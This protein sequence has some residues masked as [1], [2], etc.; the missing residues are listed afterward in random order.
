[1]AGR[2]VQ[3][4]DPEYAENTISKVYANVNIEMGPDWYDCEKWIMPTTTSLESYYIAKRLGSGKYSDVFT[5]YKGD[6]IYA[7][8]I[9]KPL[10]P[11]K[12]MKEAKILLN[13]R[14]GPNIIGLYDIL[15]N[16]ITLQYSFVFEYVKETPYK[17]LFQRMS[18]YDCRYYLYQLLLALEYAHS[19]GIM[20]RD[21]KPLNICYTPETRTL[22]LIDWGLADFYMPGQNYGIHVATKNYKAPELLLDYQKYDYSVDMWSFGVTMA[23]MIFKKLPFFKGTDD[24]DMI[25]KIASVLGGQKLKEYLDKYNLPLPSPLQNSMFRPRPKPWWSFVTGENAGLATDDAIDLIDKCLRFDHM[26][27]ITAKEALKHPYFDLVRNEK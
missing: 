23:G 5:A 15:Q 16:P 10:K 9:L 20:H 4:T 11:E 7:V 3:R 27:R 13:L 18:D 19:H 21:V 14:G 6:Q 24:I 8:K 26:E 22:R 2:A 12:Y 1:M 17:I 25:E